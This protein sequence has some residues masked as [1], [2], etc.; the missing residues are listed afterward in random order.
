MRRGK[1]E[2][3]NRKPMKA[4]QPK[5]WLLDSGARWPLTPPTPPTPSAVAPPPPAD[6]VPPVLKHSSAVN[7]RERA[8]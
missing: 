8:S 2:K 1:W 4:Y 7:Q 5:T 6:E 3:T